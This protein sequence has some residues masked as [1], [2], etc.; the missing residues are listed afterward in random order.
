MEVKVTIWDCKTGHEHFSFP[1]S[2][3]SADKF[4]AGFPNAFSPDGRRFACISV[5]EQNDK[6]A[7]HAKIWDVQTGN[8]L[9]DFPVSG[10]MVSDL[11]FSADGELF[12]AA[13]SM[14]AGDGNLILFSAMSEVKIWN[15]VT[16]LAQASLQ[17]QPGPMI[18]LALSPDG[19]RIATTSSVAGMTGQTKNEVKLWDTASGA[20]L[21]SLGSGCVQPSMVFSADGRRILLA[22]LNISGLFN[23]SMGVKIWDA[24]PRQ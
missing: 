18:L 10:S 17:G 2:V 9:A 15:T 12:A 1:S 4:S 7:I 11:K 14:S 20:E 19:K 8:E 21:L 13:S 24:T 16:G 3:L 6:K 5:I 23:S 22:G